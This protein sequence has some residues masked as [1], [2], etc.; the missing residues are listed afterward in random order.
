MRKGDLDR[1]KELFEQ[2]EPLSQLST[3]R[4]QNYG[5]EHN[6]SEFRKWAR[7][8]FHFRDF[9]QIQKA[10]NYLVTEGL[11]GQT[12]S[13]EE[14]D[15][16]GE[17]LRMEVA[18]AIIRK[19]KDVDV[20][21]IC[22]Q[23]GLNSV[24]LASMLVTAGFGA[25]D[26]GDGEQALSLFIEAMTLPSF[27]EVSDD[28]LRAIGVFLAVE[29]RSDIAA[30]LFEALIPPALSMA[31]KELTSGAPSHLVLAVLEYAQLCAMLGKVQ[32]KVTPSE[33]DFL[34]PLQD[35]AAAIGELLGHTLAGINPTQ[36]G[37]VQQVSRA[38]LGH[39]LRLRPTSGSDFYLVDLAMRA[40]PTLAMTLMQVGMRQGEETYRAVL[41][42]ID[43]AINASTLKGTSFLRRELAVAAYRIDGDSDSAKVRLEPISDVLLESTPTEQLNELANLAISFSAIG[44]VERGRMLLATILDHCLGYALAA[45]KDPQYSL[46]NDV[47]IHA[48]AADPENR[49]QRIYH[50]LRQVDGMKETEGSSAAH[51]LT[52]VLIDEA[53]QINARTGS[54][55][56]KILMEWQLLSWPNYIDLQLIGI[57]RRRPDMSQACVSIWCGLCLP[58]YLE[59]HYRDPSHVGDFI[60]AAVRATGPSSVAKIASVLQKEI[61]INSRAHER[62]TLLQ[63]LR[64]A[65]ASQGHQS[66][67]IENAIARWSGEAPSPRRSYSKQKYDDIEDLLE[68]RRAFELDGE[69]LD[70]HAPVRFLSLAESAPL[71]LVREIFD[72]WE[73]LQS[74]TR[75]RFMLIN[76][77]IGEGHIADARQLFQ[78]HDAGGPPLGYWTQW[79]GGDKFYYY[80]AKKQFEGSSIQKDIYENFVD[81]LISGEESELG[82]LAEIESILPLI[83]ETPDWAAIWTCLSEQMTFT[84]EYQL[85]TEFQ[86]SEGDFSDEELLADLIISGLRMPIFEVQRHGRNCMQQ[87]GNQFDSGRLI[88]ETVVRRMFAGQYEEPRLALQILE[89]MDGDVIFSWQETL[90]RLILHKDLAVAESASFLLQ[91]CHIRAFVEVQPLPLFYRLELAGAADENGEEDWENLL[92]PRTGAM[93]VE[94]SLCWTWMLRPIAKTLAEL[95]DCDEVNIRRR[96]ADFIHEWG[97]IEEFGDAGLKRLEA[98]LGNMSMKMTYLKPHG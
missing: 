20:Q 9:E 17:D 97:G 51:R 83:C 85:G 3:R 54:D 65:A 7:R 96:A 27:H 12:L 5:N 67:S 21:G 53:M 91:R 78:K 90:Q 62:V 37:R 23:L 47:L 92:D 29:G 60:D 13:A 38:A 71:Q 36:S 55:V 31:D 25:R 35:H 4:F 86:G 57:L 1:A 56:A 16:I 42:E 26:R 61:E 6:L 44:D 76:R 94:D 98:H 11:Q 64:S 46:W 84:R 14:K 15:R 40:I 33:H 88:F 19:Q 95:A 30:T 10:I 8:V 75:C 79:M 93:R 80:S 72:R 82:L 24:D 28:D 43:E 50:L 87:L 34:R 69:K 73:E 74:S 66:Q 48:N 58:Y 77:L 68:L 59:P 70:Y 18:I 41:R 49:A 22:K 52:M 39:I 32:P 89:G 63:R 81:S 45:R 2:L